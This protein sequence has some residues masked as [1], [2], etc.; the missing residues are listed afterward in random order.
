MR[1][2]MLMRIRA[3]VLIASTVLVGIGITGITAAH[4]NAA[5]AWS[6]VLTTNFKLQAGGQAYCMDSNSAGADYTAKCS[7]TSRS[8]VWE[9]QINYDSPWQIR[10]AD[11]ATGWCLDSN[12][13]GSSY[14]DPCNGG[15]YQNWTELQN[16][17]ATSYVVFQDVQTGLTLDANGL[18]VNLVTRARNAGTYQSWA[19]GTGG[20]AGATVSGPLTNTYNGLCSYADATSVFLNPCSQP[21]NNETWRFLYDAATGSSNIQVMVNGEAAG[22]LDYNYLPGQIN[23]TIY[24]NTTCNWGLSQSW[25]LSQGGDG[26]YLITSAFNGDNLAVDPYEGAGADLYLQSPSPSSNFQNWTVDFTV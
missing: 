25:S 12:T 4:A 9:V 7:G 1:K 2:R 5:E 26:G 13:A 17:A 3:S 11:L 8:Q 19:A 15:N 20:P 18:G 16:P 24:A 6:T 23:R 10:F 22:C 14:T 21:Y